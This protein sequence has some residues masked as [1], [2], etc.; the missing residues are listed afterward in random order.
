MSGYQ[1]RAPRARLVGASFRSR[2]PTRDDIAD[3]ALEASRF[4]RLAPV[5]GWCGAC[6]VNVDEVHGK[7]HAFDCPH[8]PVE[9]RAAK[10]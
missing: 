2:G 7:L 5:L 3:I 9:R 10:T 1:K 4:Q 6:G 8:L